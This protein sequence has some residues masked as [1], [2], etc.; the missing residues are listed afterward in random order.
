MLAVFRE[1]TAELEEV[2]QHEDDSFLAEGRRL[3]AH[4]ELHEALYRAVLGSGT[5]APKLR[6]QLAI[7]VQGHLDQHKAALPD[8]AIP[9][10]V[11]AQHMVS[12][13]LGLVDYWLEGQQRYTVDQMAAFYERLIVRATWYAL[14]PAH[15][16]SFPWE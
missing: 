5:F 11:A 12:S 14:L 9:L 13:F 15:E 4:V 6:H 10:D 8:P 16:M 1:I 3:F 2:Q 7:I